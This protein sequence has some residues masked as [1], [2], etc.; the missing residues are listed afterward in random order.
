MN[1]FDANNPVNAGRSHFLSFAQAINAALRQAMELDPNVFVCGIGADTASGIFGTTTGLAEHFGSKRVF[2]TPIAE[3]GLTALA[4]GAANAGLR[5]V[6][7]H[8]RL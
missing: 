8:Q 3:A 2:D 6:L 7:I 4:A 1:A 5:P